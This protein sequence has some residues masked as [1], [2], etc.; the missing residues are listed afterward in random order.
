M[1]RLQLKMRATINH[2]CYRTGNGSDRI[3]SAQVIALVERWIRSLP[4]PVL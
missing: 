1:N 3:L 2:H 4:L